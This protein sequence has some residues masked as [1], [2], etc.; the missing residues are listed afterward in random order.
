ME[1]EMLALIPKSFRAECLWSCG[2][3]LEAI[4]HQLGKGAL[5][6]WCQQQN[7]GRASVWAHQRC[8]RWSRRAVGQWVSILIKVSWALPLGYQSLPGSHL[9]F[10]TPVSTFSFSPC[11]HPKERW[12]GMVRLVSKNHFPLERCHFSSWKTIQRHSLSN[13][14]YHP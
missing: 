5:K 9:T 1:K 4:S 8:C 3:S 14:I 6:C 2:H 13:T 10:Y 11:S 12:K 7:W